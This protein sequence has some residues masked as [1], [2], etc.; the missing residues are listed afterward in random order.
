ML[1]Q[2]ENWLWKHL[3]SLVSPANVLQYPWPSYNNVPHACMLISSGYDL[4]LDVAINPASA[5]HPIM[6]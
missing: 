2:Y 5:I 6:T 3:L 4:A 1:L